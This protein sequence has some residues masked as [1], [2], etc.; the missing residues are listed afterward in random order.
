MERCKRVKLRSNTPH[1]SCLR[2]PLRSPLRPPF[3]LLLH[4][5]ISLSLQLLVLSGWSN[6]DIKVHSFEEISNRVPGL[7]PS[8]SRGRDEAGRLHPSFPAA[9]AWSSGC[10]ADLRWLLRL[11]DYIEAYEQRG[12]PPKP[13]TISSIPSIHPSAGPFS[14]HGSKICLLWRSS[15]L[16]HRNLL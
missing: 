7:A 4:G 3:L 16:F 14:P 12:F 13:H 1:R 2:S 5:V 10:S 11:G 9:N 8:P 15:G 6:L